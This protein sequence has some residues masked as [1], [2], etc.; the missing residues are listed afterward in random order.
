MALVRIVCGHKGTVILNTDDISQVVPFMN[1]KNDSYCKVYFRSKPYEPA[2]LPMS[3][4]ELWEDYLDPSRNK[5][6]PLTMAIRET[7]RLLGTAQAAKML[8]VLERLY[9]EAKR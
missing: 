4:D 5:S 6:D 8:S 2:S 7:D 9:R 1:E 3:V